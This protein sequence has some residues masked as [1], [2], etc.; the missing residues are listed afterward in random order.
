MKESSGLL[1]RSVYAQR[2]EAF[3]SLLLQALSCY[4]EPS[5]GP[6]CELVLASFVLCPKLVLIVEEMPA[7]RGIKLVS[8]SPTALEC[9]SSVCWVEAAATC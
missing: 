4:K 6:V 8:S 5:L 9:P 1:T 7:V 3:P 2:P